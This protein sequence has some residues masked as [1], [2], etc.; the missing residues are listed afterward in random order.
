[1]PKILKRAIYQLVVRFS[2]LRIE[3]DG[4]NFIEE[5]LS[6]TEVPVTQEHHRH[7]C[8]VQNNKSPIIKLIIQKRWLLVQICKVKSFDHIKVEYSYQG[9][10]EEEWD[11]KTMSER[12]K[13]L[14]HDVGVSEV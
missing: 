9:N 6:V 1:M 10:G 13:D 14:V 5:H 3:F 12:D 8:I 2:Y 7:W 11:G 4:L